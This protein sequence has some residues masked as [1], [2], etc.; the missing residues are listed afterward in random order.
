MESISV[1]KRISSITIIFFAL[2]LFSNII[3]KA[4]GYVPPG[5]YKNTCSNIQVQFGIISAQCQKTDGSWK[6]TQLNYKDCEGDISNQ[7]GVLTCKHSPKPEKPLPRGSYKQSC[8]NAYVEGKWLYA[9]CQKTNGNWSNSSIKYSDCNKDIWNNNGVL[10]CGGGSN[11]PKGSYKQSCKDA[12]VEGNWLYAKCQK[13]N[14]SWYNSSIKYSDCNKDIWN[15][16]G[17]LTCGG[18]GSSNLPKG[19]YKETCNNIYVEGN[20]LEADCLNRNGKYSHSGIKYKNC[21]RGIW[22]NK[23][24]LECN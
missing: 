14:G 23:G 24:Q 1:V 19:S 21:S 4:Q 9:K 11:L 8:Q 17:V 15:N 2:F 12:Y 10:T 7:N 16:N 13:N 18:G 5:S 22:N 20:I 6:A 3:A